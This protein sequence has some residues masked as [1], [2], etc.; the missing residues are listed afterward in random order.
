[1]NLRPCGN[2][3]TRFGD[4][5]SFGCDNKGTMIQQQQQKYDATCCVLRD[6]YDLCEKNGNLNNS[7]RVN[8]WKR[9][10]ITNQVWWILILV[11]VCHKVYEVM[12]IDFYAFN[13]TMFYGVGDKIL[14]IV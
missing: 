8:H 9:M 13:G 14:S 2:D 10:V 1:M 6:R 11:L 4:R 12:M 7:Q 5:N 3:K